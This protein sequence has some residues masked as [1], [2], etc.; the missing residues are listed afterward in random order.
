VKNYRDTIGL[1]WN[2]AGL[3]ISASSP[4][5]TTENPHWLIAF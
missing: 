4:I 2:L 5:S 1:L 3:E